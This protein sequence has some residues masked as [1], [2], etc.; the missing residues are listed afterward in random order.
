MRNV[1]Q[2]YQGVSLS[3]DDGYGN[4]NVLKNIY[5]RNRDY[6]GMFASCS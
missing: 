3:G 5:L 2:S 1:N 4:E 6:L